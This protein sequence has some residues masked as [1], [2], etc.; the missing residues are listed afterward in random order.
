V[1]A[2]GEDL[3]LEREEGAAGVDQVDARQPVLLGDLLR[4]EVL[5][6]GQREVGA[7]LHGRVVRDDHALA[8][9]DHPDPGDD[10]CGRRLTV[11]DLPGGEGGEL[12]EGAARIDE[13]VDALAGRQLPARAVALERRLASARGDPRR[14]FA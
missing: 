6:H 9:L 10:A 14:A 13:Q 8:A 11:V 12:E 1:I 7:A 2:V 5:L 3:R 4:T